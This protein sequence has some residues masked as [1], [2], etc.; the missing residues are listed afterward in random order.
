MVKRRIAVGK[1]AVIVDLV[2]SRALLSGC[3]LY[4][5]WYAYQVRRM[6]QLLLLYGS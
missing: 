3:H 1:N 6:I 5:T 4:H 2:E